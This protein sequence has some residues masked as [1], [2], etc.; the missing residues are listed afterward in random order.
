MKA[1]KISIL[2]ATIFI[3]TNLWNK[4]NGA[5][6]HEQKLIDV[7]NNFFDFD[8]NIFLFHS[9]V[10]T[11]RFINTRHSATKTPQSV[12]VYRSVSNDD[13]IQS[14]VLSN[15][16]SKNTFLVVAP[17]R[18]V[19]NFDSIRNLLQR[20]KASIRRLRLWIKIGIFL[21]HQVD[22]RNLV[23]DIFVWCWDERIVQIFATVETFSSSERSLSVFALSP[24][25]T[26]GVI[27]VTENMGYDRF[28]VSQTV[29]FQQ[30][31]LKRNNL[32]LG[33][34]DVVFWDTA[35]SMMNASLEIVSPYVITKENDIVMWQQ[36]LYATSRNNLYPWV[37]HKFTVL[38]PEAQ[39][40]P[41]FM[42]YFIALTSSGVIALSIAMI[43]LI[44]GVLSFARFM[45][46]EKLQFFNCI[47]D[48]INLIM[49][50]NG[51]I[52]YQRHSDVELFIIVPLTFVGLIF[53]NGILSALQSYVTRPVMQPQID[54]IE[55]IYKSSLM[56]A[57]RDRHSTTDALT[58]QLE[59]NWTGRIDDNGPLF[60]KMDEFNQSHCYVAADF[61]SELYLQIQ[62]RLQI[63]GYH[64]SRVHISSA[65]KS[66]S[67]YP[68]HF[69]F[70]ERLN[71]I[72]H[73]VYSAGLFTFWESI[74]VDIMAKQAWK[75]KF[76][77]MKIEELELGNNV[78]L[79][80]F[81]YYGW[82]A[83]G[84]VF[85]LEIIWKNCLLLL[86]IERCRIS[87]TT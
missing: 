20:V 24:F 3:I 30:Y 12:Y 45:R 72:L 37:V 77:T 27:N 54:T 33:P 10:D 48:V 8:H 31:S 83:S 9:T 1:V 4:V 17:G 13:N 53:V 78:Q 34:T 41:E 81:I 62:K 46:R 23:Q 32:T 43:V 85:I 84:L 87:W 68:P 66:F 49:N 79:P 25:P 18:S 75:I 67:I 5:E 50:D 15:I 74:T 22:A 51:N 2:S 73:R 55:D 70:S 7:L 36:R 71:E 61:E 40:Y 58:N 39:P 42:A 64:I 16:S 65:F 21:S 63:S 57:T 60:M 38:V 59:K 82:A 35:L 56:I 26:V 11:G 14:N 47:V 28:F 29:N 69:P 19:S 44:I 52:K 86:K 76:E 80:S 6:F